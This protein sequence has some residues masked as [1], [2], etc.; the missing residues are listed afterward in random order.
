MIPGCP[1]EWEELTAD[2]FLCAWRER[3]KLQPGKVK[4]WLATVARNRALNRLRDRRELLPLEEDVLVLAQDSPQREL[5]TR[6]AAQLVRAALETLEPSDRERV[7]ELVCARVGRRRVQ[8]RRVLLVAAALT[9][10]LGLVGWSCAEVY[11]ER[12]FQLVGGGQIT[13]GDS[14][15]EHYV[16]AHPSDGYD[17]NGKPLLVSLEEDRLWVVARGQRVD[18]TDQVDEKTPYVDTWWDGE[19]NLYYVIVGGTPEDYGWYEGVT[20]PDGSGGGSG[21][22]SSCTD[23]SPG[24]QNNV[25]WFT[26]GQ[27]QVR[28]LWYARWQENQK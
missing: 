24:E 26:R 17:E 7:K 8:K 20:V 5:E 1:Q 12:I 16:E 21:I 2:V 6:E 3:K 11:G 27:E 13:I 25:E 14:G 15:E 22:L 4:S 18:V 9:V 10:C 19:G 23:I 28:E